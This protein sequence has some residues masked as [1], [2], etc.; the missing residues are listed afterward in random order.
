MWFKHLLSRGSRSRCSTS[1]STR[2]CCARACSRRRTRTTCAPRAPRGSRERRV[3]LRHV[4]RTSLI[5]FVS[6]F[7]LDFAALVGGAAL[8]TE[9][10]FGLPGR[11]P[12]HLP[13]AAATSTC[14]VIMATVMYAAFF[15]V[16]AN[17]VV[18][19]ALRLA[20]PAGAPGMSR[21]PARGARPAGL[22]P[23]RG[24]PRAPPSTALSFTR[25]RRRGPRRSSASRARAR[26]SRCWR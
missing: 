2:G 13:V 14:R 24:R 11:R 10:V 25:R 3:L 4:L 22:L 19:I 18:D 23:H 21:A 1:A 16:L 17:A 6:L 5:P 7:G 15:V 12:A 20:R 8:L 26:A 9:V